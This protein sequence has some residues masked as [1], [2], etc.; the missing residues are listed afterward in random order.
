MPSLHGNVSSLTPV[1]SLLPNNPIFTM[2]LRRR[3][4]AVDALS[5][6]FISACAVIFLLICTI[7]YGTR[8]QNPSL[9][10]FVKEVLPA[11]RCLCEYSTTFTCD[12]CLSCA[13]SSNIVSNVTFPEDEQWSFS[14]ERDGSNYGLDQDQCHAA[15]P[16][17]FQDIERAKKVR[18][19]KKVTEL[20]LSS[21]ELTKG[22]V[23]AMIFNGEVI[24]G[25]MNDH[26]THLSLA[27]LPQA[28]HPPDQARRQHESPK[29]PGGPSITSPCYHCRVTSIPTAQR[30]VRLQRR[31]PSRTT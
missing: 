29:S 3:C 27:D 25:S 11:G 5:Y 28:L 9:P 24:I 30:R 20:E 31:R 8:T 22:M 4:S 12:T 14:Y 2:L 26:I 10:S 21:F 16:G 19:L 23:R 1:P 7:L 15:F 18:G 13:S 6:F 17:L